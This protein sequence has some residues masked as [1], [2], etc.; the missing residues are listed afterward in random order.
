MTHD[1]Q[2]FSRIERFSGSPAL[3]CVQLVIVFL[4]CAFSLVLQ[5]FDYIKIT[6]HRLIFPLHDFASSY[7]LTV[8]QVR[9]K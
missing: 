9:V 7:E 1:A 4:D 3:Y 6:N 2:R 5:W 8:A